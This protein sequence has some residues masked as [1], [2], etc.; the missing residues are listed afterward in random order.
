MIKCHLSTLMGTRKLK[1]TDVA[2]DTGLHRNTVTALYKET[3]VRIDL[4]ALETLC[5]YFNCSV[6]EML[7]LE[8]DA[9]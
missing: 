3:A 8:S 7:E 5:R 2:R 1:I 9:D 4:S 6:G